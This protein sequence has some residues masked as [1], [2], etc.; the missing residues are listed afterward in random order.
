MACSIEGGYFASTTDSPYPAVL[1]GY[2]FAHSKVTRN[3]DT[4]LDNEESGERGSGFIWRSSIPPESTV[5][6]DATP[7]CPSPPTERILQPVGGGRISTGRIRWCRTR[8]VSLQRSDDPKYPYMPGPSD[9]RPGW[10]LRA[11]F[12]FTATTERTVEVR[13]D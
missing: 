8:T 10:F 13:Q 2:K 12:D 9:V 11:S 4:A 6:V 7:S 5:R 1:L 3:M